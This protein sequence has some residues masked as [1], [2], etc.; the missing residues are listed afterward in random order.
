MNKSAQCASAKV[1]RFDNATSMSLV[2]VRKTCQPSV[3]S[4]RLIRRAQSSVNSFSGL[5]SKTLMVPPFIPDRK[6]TRLNSSHANISYAVFC[7]K[8]GHDQ[9]YSRSV[10]A[11]LAGRGVHVVSA[12][13]V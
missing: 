5:L 12:S 10:H 2:R 1:T 3:S 8:K 11:Q 13:V 4:N 7:L 6:S 9:H